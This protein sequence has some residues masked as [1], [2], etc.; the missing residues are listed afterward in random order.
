LNGARALVGG[1]RSLWRPADFFTLLVA[2]FGFLDT[3]A[4]S[5]M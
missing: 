4:A 5:G 3:E 1:G 2:P